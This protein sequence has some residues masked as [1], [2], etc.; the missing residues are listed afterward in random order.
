MLPFKLKTRKEKK[1]DVSVCLGYLSD[2]SPKPKVVVFASRDPI[3]Y[4][5]PQLLVQCPGHTRR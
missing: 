1:I 2:V 4:L 5:C 3:S